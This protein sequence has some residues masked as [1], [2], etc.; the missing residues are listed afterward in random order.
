M[1]RAPDR[2]GADRRNI[3]DEQLLDASNSAT[4]RRANRI[5]PLSPCQRIRSIPKLIRMPW[6]CPACRTPIRHGENEEGPR[7]GVI[8]RCPI[9]RL[10]LQRNTATGLLDVVPLP[11]D[12]K[13]RSRRTR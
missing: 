10:E 1:K 5:R 9:C 4:E 2:S 7:A 6:R 11:A 8:Y 12:E 3:E 13:D